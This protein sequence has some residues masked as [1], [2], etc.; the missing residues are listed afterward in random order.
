[1]KSFAVR[2]T[3]LA[4]TGVLVM[5][6]CAVPALAGPSKGYRVTVGGSALAGNDVAFNVTFS[7]PAGQQQQLGSADLTVPPGFAPLSAAIL[8]PGVGSATLSGSTIQLRNLALQPGQSVTVQVRASVP[9]VQ[10]A[11]SS[12]TVLAKQAND[13]N[14]PP[15]NTLVLDVAG[16]VLSTPVA[17]FCKPCPANGECEPA[18]VTTGSS[19]FTVQGHTAPDPGQVTLSLGAGPQIDCAGYSEVTAETTIFDVTGGRDK[20]VTAQVPKDDLPRGGHQALEFCFGAA[21]SFITKSGAPAAQ[22]GTYDFDGDGTPEPLFVGLLPDCGVL[23]APC[24]SDRVRIGDFGVIEAQLLE[25]D[26]A[27]RH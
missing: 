14:G 21:E 5:L 27:M 24:V 17:G 22:Q 6:L 7:V 15:G 13:F 3:R 20:T 26:P 10:G 11:S 12:W 2:R 8:A 9:C 18:S 1:M 4:L 25:G 16:S 23:S 19:V